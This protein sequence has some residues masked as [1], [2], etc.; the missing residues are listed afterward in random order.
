MGLTPVWRQK[1]K[2]VPLNEKEFYNFI[3]VQLNFN[4]VLYLIVHDLAA[5]FVEKSFWEEIQGA[6]NSIFQ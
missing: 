1:L 3:I 2:L 6:P 4:L 5:C